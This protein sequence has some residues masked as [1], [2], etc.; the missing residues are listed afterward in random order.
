M[1]EENKAIVRRFYQEV[2]MEGRLDVLDEIMTADFDDHGDVLFGSPQG[3][4]ALRQ[5]VAAARGSLTNMSVDIHDMIAEGDL[6][7]LRGSER[8]IQQGA[9]LGVPGSGNQLSWW[10][11]PIFRIVDGRI[12]ARWFNADSLSILQQLGIAPPTATRFSTPLTGSSQW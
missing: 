6:V 8:A 7:G 3:R 11:M 9:F 1:S 10:G 4:E 2:M 12:T 5:A